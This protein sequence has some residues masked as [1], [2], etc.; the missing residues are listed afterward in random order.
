MD[1]TLNELFWKNKKMEFLSNYMKESRTLCPYDD[2]I[3]K[4]LY[5]YNVNINTPLL[6]LLS[7]YINSV[8]Q[9]YDNIVFI[10]RYTCYLQLIYQKLFPS[11]TSEIIY[12]Q[13]TNI[14]S[15]SLVINIKENLNIDC[16]KLK[17]V[18]CLY[19]SKLLDIKNVKAV[20]VIEFLNSVRF[21]ELNTK[22]K[23][24][25]LKVEYPKYVAYPIEHNIK[26][27]LNNLKYIKCNEVEILS[28]LKQYLNTYLPD[29]KLF[30]LK[31]QFKIEKNVNK[32]NNEYTEY[33]NLFY[34]NKKPVNKLISNISIYI[35]N[36]SIHTNRKKHMIELCNK[37]NIKKYTF[38]EPFPATNDTKIQLAKLLEC[39]ESKLKNSLTAMSHSLTYYNILQNTEEECIIF[40]DD[41][42]MLNT[43]EDTKILLEYIINNYPENTNMIYLEYCFEWCEVKNKNI[44]RK[45]KMPLCTAAIYYPNKQNRL[46]IL[47]TI[48]KYCKTNEHNSTDVIFKYNI[49]NHNIIAYEHQ[50]LFYQDK[51]YGSFIEGSSMNTPF[52]MNSFMDKNK[53]FLKTQNESIPNVFKIIVCI[54]MIVLC[55]CIFL[56]NKILIG[57]VIIVLFIFI[58]VYTYC[59]NKKLKTTTLKTTEWKKTATDLY[60]NELKKYK[61]SYN[62]YKKSPQYK[63]SD[64]ITYSYFNQNEN[65]P[66]SMVKKYKKKNKDTNWFLS[67][68]QNAIKPN[69]DE[70]I[71]N[72]I[73]EDIDKHTVIDLLL[74]DNDNIKSLNYYHTILNKIKQ[75]TVKKIILI[76]GSDLNVNFKK[77]TLYI[78]C[79]KSFLEQNGM[80]VI[81]RLGKNSND[82]FIYMCNATYSS[83][84]GKYSTKIK[85]IVEKSG[86]YII[87]P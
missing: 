69:T 19:I 12:D 13:L 23:P 14:Q 82:D 40:E 10:S 47:N 2:G 27:I 67:I 59:D 87:T 37:L 31:V 60:N 48:I 11:S 64:I 17:N 6:I 63:F 53:P 22:N 8:S 49:K 85:N 45:L 78:N 65:V 15:N 43:V 70:L 18:K 72:V 29:S 75:T 7:Y 41:I 57:I 73:I 35:I 32:T 4:M 71:M 51:K 3:F 81:L 80:K 38:V 24:S 66:T 34:K 50:L 5:M 76:A 79:I 26:N 83:P 1:Y 77:S 62:L 55:L 44:W 25:F 36:Q 30:N 84:I 20:D 33:Y 58:S 86:G 39:N 68:L 74:T 9:K 42:E 21:G 16:M 56:L 46:H 28:N 52:C 54:L 61:T